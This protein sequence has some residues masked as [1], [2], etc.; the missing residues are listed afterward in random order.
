M[1]VFLDEAEL[2]RH[3]D[4]IETTR[5]ATSSGP[6]TCTASR[7]FRAAPR[8][9]RRCGRAGCAIALASSSKAAEL[10][11]Y[12]AAAGIEGLTDVETSSDDAER[13]KPHPD[14]FA[15]AHSPNSTCRQTA[16]S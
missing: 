16:R 15:A 5:A 11:V 9:S 2:K 8:S 14:I 7:A 4:D 6:N 3:G 1:P 13:S 12:K 10:K